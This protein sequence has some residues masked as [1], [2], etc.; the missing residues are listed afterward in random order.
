MMPIL[1]KPRTLSILIALLARPASTTTR[2]A[3]LTPEQCLGGRPDAPVRV[4][5]FS[6]YECG[7]SR[8]HN[9]DV[10]RN[11]PEEYC[12]RNRVCVVYDESPPWSR[13]HGRVAASYSK[14]AQRSGQ[15]NGGR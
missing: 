10:I 11:V 6:D 1:Q 4:E 3:E 14:A 9:L 5:V 7:S 12:S 15:K 2:E 8:T 13:G